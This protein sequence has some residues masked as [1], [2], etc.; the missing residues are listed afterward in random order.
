M[1]ELLY[2]V[3]R[4][5]ELLRDPEIL[6]TEVRVQ[7]QRK[8]GEGVGVVEAPRGTL[9]HHYRANEEGRVTKANFVVSTAHNKVA[10]DQSVLWV[11]RSIVADAK[12]DESRLNL[13]EMAIRCYDPCLSCSTHAHGHMPL[14]V[15]LVDGHGRTLQTCRYGDLARP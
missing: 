12:I 11:A 8:G 15:T 7:V 3:E 13:I 10:M 9:F 2:C 14:E 5:M 6:S 1:I 4:A